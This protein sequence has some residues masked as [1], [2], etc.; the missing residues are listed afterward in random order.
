MAITLGGVTLT[1]VVIDNEFG[2]SEV[3]SIVEFAL[4]GTPLIWEQP[5]VSKE[6]DLVGGDDFA[7]MD[8]TTLLA[9]QALARAI[10]ATYTLSYEGATKTV[11]FRNEAPP[12]IEA[13]PV[14]AR[15]NQAAGDWYGGII[16]RLMEV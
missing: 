4:D 15:P 12:V 10:G 14:I 5:K 7:W 8:R 13:T 16:I 1:D 6:I 11:R 2:I 9:L 3:E